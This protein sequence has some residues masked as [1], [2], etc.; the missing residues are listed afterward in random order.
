MLRRRVYLLRHADV[1]YTDAAGRF[2]DPD[3]V[4]LTD[5]GREE[6]CAVA[7]SLRTIPLDR[8][9]HSGLPRTE[10]TAR[11]V[12]AGRTL[13]PEVRDALQEIRPGRAGAVAP[14]SFEGTFLAAL[15]RPVTREDRFLG[16]EAWGAFQDRVLPCFQA[17]LAD[18][19]WRHLLVVAHGGVNRV[20]LLDALGAGLAGLGRIEQDP[21]GLNVLD[22]DEDG[23]VLVRLLNHTAYDPAKASLVLTTM[24]KLLRDLRPARK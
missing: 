16:G 1:R 9:V 7:E 8:A 15:H 2:V 20:I 6:A 5:Q 18:P 13:R 23:H 17:L 19:S 24:E 4:S 21:A 3:T 12:L 14:E 10:E 11:L 22:V